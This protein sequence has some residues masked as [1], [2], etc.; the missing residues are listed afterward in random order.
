ME[1]GCQFGLVHLVGVALGLRAARLVGRTDRGADRCGAST[2]AAGRHSGGHSSRPVRPSARHA[3]RRGLAHHRTG[4]VRRLRAAGRVDVSGVRCSGG[5]LWYDGA[6]VVLRCANPHGESCP[7]RSPSQHGDVVSQSWTTT[8]SP[9][10]PPRSSTRQRSG[11]WPAHLRCQGP[12]TFR[13]ADNWVTG[14]LKRQCASRA[15][16][17][18]VP[19]QPPAAQLPCANPT[20]CLPRRWRRAEPAPGAWYGRGN[21]CSG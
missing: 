4:V 17:N 12:S 7:G 16:L 3:P 20:R 10:C 1:P 19:L 15:D 5:A 8:C 13:S 18:A 9:A 21:S 14:S 2:V 11:E 6:R